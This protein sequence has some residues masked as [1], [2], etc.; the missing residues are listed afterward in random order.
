MGSLRNGTCNLLLSTQ[1]ACTGRHNLGHSLA[2]HHGRSISL[3]HE[4]CVLASLNSLHTAPLKIWQAHSTCIRSPELDCN[5]GELRRA[6]SYMY[7]ILFSGEGG[8]KLLPPP[9]PPPKVHMQLFMC[10]V[11]RAQEVTGLHYT[12]NVHARK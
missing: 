8:G 11:E 2:G 1:S 12:R 5:H 4:V 7:R 3:K 10:A 9:P 6:C